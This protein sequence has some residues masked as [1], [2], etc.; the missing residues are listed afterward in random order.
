MIWSR[1]DVYAPEIIFSSLYD[2]ITSQE[3]RYPVL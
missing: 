2:K 1:G 3:L